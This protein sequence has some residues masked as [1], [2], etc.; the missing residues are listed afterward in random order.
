MSN[1]EI[2]NRYKKEREKEKRLAKTKLISETTE[3]IINEET[4]ETVTTRREENTM[5]V[6]KEPPY[7]KLYIQDM[8]Y[9]RKV[10]KSLTEFTYALLKRLR[11]A[12]DEEGPLCIILSSY[13]K[14]QILAE[15][16]FEKMGTIN[17]YLYK[18][19]K[20]DI[21]K[22]ID[23]NTYQFNPFIFGRG[24]WKDISNIRVTWD[25]N[26]IE[27][28]TN[29][30]STTILHTSVHDVDVDDEDIQAAFSDVEIDEDIQAV[31]SE[32]DWSYDECNDNDE[33]DIT[34]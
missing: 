4:G 26:L 13:V 10:P 23:T 22:R 29:E 31:F 9:L 11:Y 20:F 25:Y 27:G 19:C 1:S 32:S 12:S 2:V 21:L 18:L 30:V 28:T 33:E 6:L 8:L 17:S 14:K 16:K 34:E 3:Y 15:L 24:E 7:I 5:T